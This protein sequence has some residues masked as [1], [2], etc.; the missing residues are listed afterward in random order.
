MKKT[1][2]L[3]ILSSVLLFMGCPDRIDNTFDSNIIIVNNANYD[4][5][6]DIVF[7]KYP[8]KTLYKS[9]PFSDTTQYRL[10]LI[11]SKSQ[12]SNPGA[13]IAGF[14]RNQTPVMLF[15]FSRDTVD[16]V[17]WEKIRNEY[18]VL[19]R[20][21]LTKAKLDSLNWTISYP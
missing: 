2:F 1:S 10:S 8:D 21:D 3:F 11:R 17:P 12:G 19:R 14:E 5:L 13:W 7:D 4:I 6:I 15:L 20:Y 18:K 16:K 9:S